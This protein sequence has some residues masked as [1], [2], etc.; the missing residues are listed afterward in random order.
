MYKCLRLQ[1]QP[2]FTTKYLQLFFMLPYTKSLHCTRR[3]QLLLQKHKL[4]FYCNSIFFFRRKTNLMESLASIKSSC[5]ATGSSK[6]RNIHEV[7]SYSTIISKHSYKVSHYRLIPPFCMSEKATDACTVLAQSLEM[8]CQVLP[9]V[10]R[11]SLV[12]DIP[13]GDGNIEKIFL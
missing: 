11:W 10:T 9:V 3:K 13:A 2:R 12:S 8:F 6:T 1:I 5:L 7:R 4:V